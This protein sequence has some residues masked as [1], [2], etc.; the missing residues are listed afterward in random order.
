MDVSGEVADILVKEGM[1]AVEEALKFTGKGA[2]NAAAFLA[3]LIKQNYQQVGQVGVKRLMK[4]NAEAVCIPIREEDLAAFKKAAKQYGVLFAAVKNGNRT[5]NSEQTVQIISN[6]NYAASLNAVLDG[7]G[8]TCVR[9]KMK[10]KEDREQPKKTRSQGASERESASDVRRDTSK[11]SPETETKPRVKEV[12]KEAAEKAKVI[13]TSA[14]EQERGAG[15]RS[16]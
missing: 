3:A 12:L 5:E 16:Y 9:D 15:G 6:A 14:K 11:Q 2:V 1:F 7:M 4:E 13:S 10:K 8:Y